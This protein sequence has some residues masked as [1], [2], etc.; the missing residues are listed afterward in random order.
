MI[1]S[2]LFTFL[3]WVAVPANGVTVTEYRYLD[4][5]THFDQP[6]SAFCINKINPLYEYTFIQ[7][8]RGFQ[9]YSCKISFVAQP[10]IGSS[11]AP[12]RGF[13]KI[14]FASTPVIESRLK[15]L[16]QKDYLTK[17]HGDDI[18]FYQLPES[19]YRVLSGISA[20]NEQ[21]EIKD[22]FLGLIYPVAEFESSLTAACTVAFLEIHNSQLCDD[23]ISDPLMLD[24]DFQTNV[25]KIQNK[26]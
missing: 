7:N 19:A 5:E 14:S 9:K 18:V 23:T 6:L 25:L 8:N 21:R 22:Q 17:E 1:S 16:S 26:L 12:T 15:L 2:L 13:R 20:D 3:Q 11:G 10:K 4:G 24:V